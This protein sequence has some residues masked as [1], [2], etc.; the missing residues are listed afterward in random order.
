YPRDG[1]W[2]GVGGLPGADTCHAAESR[3]AAASAPLGGD[4]ARPGGGAVEGARPVRRDPALEA[5]AAAPAVP[6]ADARS[7]NPPHTS[8]RAASSTAK[9][10]SGDSSY[11]RT[12]R[13][14]RRAM[15]ISTPPDGD[16]WRSFRV[17]MRLAHGWTQ[18]RV[19]QEWNRRW[20]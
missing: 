17:A 8:G 10:Q 18:A 20:P 2:G 16:P 11:S 1:G 13:A 19:A 14:S 9:G 5:A 15:S 12:H 7:S 6:P 3:R 4:A